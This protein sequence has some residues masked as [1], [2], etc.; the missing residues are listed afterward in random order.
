MLSF[1]CDSG[2]DAGSRFTGAYGRESYVAKLAT[3]RRASASFAPARFSM[4]RRF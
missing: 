3:R 2:A 4:R 1:P